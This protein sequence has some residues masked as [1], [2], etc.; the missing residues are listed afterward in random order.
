VRYQISVI[1]PVYNVEQYIT[2][3]LDSIVNQTLGI[4]HIEVIIVND[5]TPDNS[6]HIAKKYSEQYPSIKI[7][8]REKNGG[9]GEARNT[10]LE[11]V[12][13]QIVTFVDPD[14]FISIN[15]FEHVLSIFSKHQCDLVIYEYDY[16]SKSG[17]AYPRN[18]SARLFAND[19]LITDLT[20]YP[21]IIFSTSV[22][23]KV[24]SKKLIQHLHFQNMR[25][26][27]VLPSILTLFH[28]NAVYVTNQCKYYYR[29]RENESIASTMD[30]YLEKKES[31]YDHLHVNLAL[32]R[33]ISEF[34]QYKVLIDWFNARTY[35]TFL[36]NM[37]NKSFFSISEKREIFNKAKFFLVNISNEA[38]ERLES[39]FHKV[40]IRKAQEKSFIH[41]VCYMTCLGLSNKIQKIPQ[42]MN[43]FI[44][45]LFNNAKKLLEF[46][47][48]LFLSLFFRGHKK[49]SNI[50]LICDRGYDAQDNGYRFFEYLR[51]THPEI[52]AYYLVDKR[53]LIDFEKVRKLGHTV[54]F[55]SMKHKVLFILAKYLISAHKG[56][57]EPWNYHIY[58]KLFSRI[59]N[60]RYIFLQHGI[61]KDNVSAILGKKNTSFD[62]FITGAR[63][64]Y[65][66]ILKE[67][68][69]NKDEVAYTG[70]SRFDW[71]H[72]FSLKNQ[73]LLMPTWRNRVVQKSHVS[74]KNVLDQQFKSSD[75]YRKYQSLINNNELIQL[76]NEYDFRLI[77]YPH[78]EV[79][80]YLKYFY[81]RT[82]RIILASKDEYDVQQLLKESQLLITDFSSV[83]FDFAYMEKP[84]IYYQFDKYKF[85]YEHY[86]KGYFDYEKHGF[87]PVCMKEEELIETIT[88]YFKNGF[89]LE[90][91]YLERINQFFELRDKN[92]CE[93]IYKAIINLK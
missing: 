33:L 20:K 42:K 57:I 54:Q 73:I 92:N 1:I 21:E 50:W 61:T 44:K 46:V 71:L 51:N 14:D 29:K 53:S 74:E 93:R 88:H 72:D 91:K 15:T 22:C 85:F 77:F 17:R 25:F 63:P 4:E 86:K 3:C 11:Y 34:P 56:T 41:F 36:Y 69:Y 67:F 32:N 60:K 65:E 43:I 19:Q 81:T 80:P 70:F 52:N 37:I 75:Y 58:K 66:Y 62:L 89:K 18:P 47:L 5:C 6:M 48:A 59:S 16:F 30:N 13:S 2:E 40:I 55:K 28:A 45:I 38:V 10:G 9:A 31:Y 26:E 84:L 79:Q 78:Y 12:T 35:A 87:G 64:E 27:D 49:Y 39:T 90:D 76:L 68:G 7:I 83:F 23:N 82:D 24:F 8:E